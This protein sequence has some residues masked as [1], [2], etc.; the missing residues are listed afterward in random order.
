MLNQFKPEVLGRLD[1]SP[2]VLAEVRKGMRAVMEP[3]GT[4]YSLF[5][6]FPADVA[7]AG[8]TGT[9]QTGLPGDDKNEDYHGVFCGFCPL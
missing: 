8:K 5:K 1:A 7:V 9:S 4:A 2:E 6:D 3:G